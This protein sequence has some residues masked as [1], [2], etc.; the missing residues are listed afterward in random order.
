M[1]PLLFIVIMDVIDKDIGEYTPWVMLLADYLVL[2]DSSHDHL[3]RRLGIWWERMERVGLKLCRS[4]TEYPTP[5]GEDG[6]I[7]MK[8]YNS[9]EMEPLPRCTQFKYQ[10]TTIHQEGDC[11]AEV[12]LHISKTWNKWRESLVVNPGT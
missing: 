6:K 8:K 10:G 3:E 2:C 4:K 5:A 9:E 1:S 12:E 7:L 11:P